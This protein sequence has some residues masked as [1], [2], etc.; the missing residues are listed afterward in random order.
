VPVQM[1]RISRP[2]P[3]LQNANPIVFKHDTV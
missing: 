1:G 3:V 2:V